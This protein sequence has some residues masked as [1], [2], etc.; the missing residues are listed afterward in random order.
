MTYTFNFGFYITDGK[1]RMYDSPRLE[2][3]AD[4]LMHYMVEHETDLVFDSAVGAVLD[5]GEVDV[6]VEVSARNE[7]MARPLARDFVSEAIR[8]I[9]GTPIGLFV[10]GDDDEPPKAPQAPQEWHERRAELLD[11]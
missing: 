2:R 7:R 8:A 3:L 5:A 9:G 1:S 11:A 6:E 4:E 10:F